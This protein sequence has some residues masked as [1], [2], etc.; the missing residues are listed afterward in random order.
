MTTEAIEQGN[1][2]AEI[3]DGFVVFLRMSGRV[4]RSKQPVWFLPCAS[5]RK[6][7]RL[8]K[9]WVSEGKLGKPVLH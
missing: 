3:E 5:K 9:R 2:R 1:R 6:A 7:R 4:R 8:A